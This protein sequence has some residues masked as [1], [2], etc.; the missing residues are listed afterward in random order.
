VETVA[1]DVAMPPDV[2]TPEDFARLH[3]QS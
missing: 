2:D 1:L 3:V